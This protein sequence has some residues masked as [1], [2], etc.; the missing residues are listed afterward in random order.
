MHN[1]GLEL[2]LHK[3]VQISVI[4]ILEVQPMMIQLSQAWPSLLKQQG[5]MTP[6]GTAVYA[7]LSY[8]P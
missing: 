2:R 3:F 5:V 4:I 8:W 1:T 6:C 7:L